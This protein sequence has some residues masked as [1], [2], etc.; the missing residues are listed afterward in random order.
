MAT[1]EQEPI[2]GVWGQSPQRGPWA[3][4]VVRGSGGRNPPEVEII[5]VTGCLTEP[6]NLAPFQKCPF[7]LRYT[8]RS[9]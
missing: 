5:L 1:A 6:A 7:E 8:Q 9:P 3:E 2:M 4:V